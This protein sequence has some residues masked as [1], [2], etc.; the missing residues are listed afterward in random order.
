M[1]EEVSFLL[2]ICGKDRFARTDRAWDWAGYAGLALDL[3]WLENG[4]PILGGRFKTSYPFAERLLNEFEQTR[5]Q[6]PSQKQPEH[7][8]E[9]ALRRRGISGL[10]GS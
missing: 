6:K 2:S 10:S 1:A 9:H 7:P 8:R 4:V 3:G 5:E